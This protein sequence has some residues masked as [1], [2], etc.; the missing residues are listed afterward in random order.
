VVLGDGWEV[1]EGIGDVM[2]G[3]EMTR[4]DEKRQC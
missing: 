3:E 4:R 2:D 1:G